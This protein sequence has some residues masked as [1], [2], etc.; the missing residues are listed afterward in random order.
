MNLNHIVEDIR[1]IQDIQALAENE[2]YKGDLNK[3][4]MIILSSNADDKNLTKQ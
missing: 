1:E 3:G 4:G 2:E